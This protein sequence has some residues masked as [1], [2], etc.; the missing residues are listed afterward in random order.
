M[1]EITSQSPNTRLC[2]YYNPRHKTQDTRFFYSD[3][4]IKTP[5]CC[6][7]TSNDRDVIDYFY[8]KHT[9]DTFFWGP[10]F[11]E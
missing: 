5:Q 3:I 2:T 10:L 7:N 8:I 9:E 1:V 11:M 4:D 6:E